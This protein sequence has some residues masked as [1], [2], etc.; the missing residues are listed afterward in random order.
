RR[1]R[2]QPTAPAAPS[3]WRGS[4]RAWRQA[5]PDGRGGLAIADGAQRLTV[6]PADVRLVT[7]DLG[8]V[9]PGEAIRL[10]PLLGQSCADASAM[11]T[12][13]GGAPRGLPAAWWQGL[14]AD[15]VA[16]VGETRW[17]PDT[18]RL[19]WDEGRQLLL[20]QQTEAS[21]RLVERVLD[22][23]DARGQCV[24][25]LHVEIQAGEA[26]VQRFELHVPRWR[27]VRAGAGAAT[28]L[29]ADYDVECSMDCWLADPILQPFECG[30]GIAATRY[31]TEGRDR[32]RL[33]VAWGPG[34]PR[35]VSLECGSL[36]VA[37]GTTLILEWCPQ[38]GAQEWYG[39]WV[40]GDDDPRRFRLAPDVH[41]RVDLGAEPVAPAPFARTWRVAAQEPEATAQATR[42]RLRLLG[43]VSGRLGESRLAFD[44]RGREAGAWLR[45][46]PEAASETVAGQ[47]GAALL[48][49]TPLRGAIRLDARLVGTAA[50]PLGLDLDLAWGRAPAARR[51][52][53]VV[54]ASMDG[55]SR[56]VPA[57][58]PTTDVGRLARR[59]HLEDGAHGALIWR[60]DFGRGAERVRLIV[61][62]LP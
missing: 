4:P 22:E 12:A 38:N 30:V 1:A 34:P 17:P 24:L 60:A 5:R 39:E 25:P 62:R 41:A 20:V 45:P 53:P 37:P 51:T 29:V 11:E 55:R 49:E 15:L 48:G 6:P 28:V 31:G 21:L 16:R 23:W 57:V 56:Q 14:A 58:L 3:P 8:A 40:P 32:L 52:V 59:L 2:S 43:E 47:R 27:E 9:A 36:A 54:L 13:W 18:T 10:E 50:Q 35:P 7:Y 46:S 19:A 42:Y 44:A 26:P 61:E 33:A